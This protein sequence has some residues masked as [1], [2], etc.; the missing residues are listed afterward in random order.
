[1]TV[2]SLD[3]RRRRKHP[4]WNPDKPRHAWEDIDVDG[5]H[6]KCSHCWLAYHSEPSGVG[7]VKAWSHGSRSGRSKSLGPCPGPDGRPK[8]TL[9]PDAP[10]EV[11]AGGGAV[12]PKP[13]VQPLCA[14]CNPPCGR[15]GRLHLG[16]VS[17]AEVVAR[18]AAARAGWI[19]S[20]R[21]KAGAA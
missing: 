14:R 12:P 7:Y 21:A 10:L 11:A 18:A 16:G 6:H 3:E 9:V 8:L 17:C 5:H 2:V 20:L 13:S 4:A 19:R 1:M 15:P